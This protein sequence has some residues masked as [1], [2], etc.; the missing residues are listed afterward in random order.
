MPTVEHMQDDLD[1]VAERQELAANPEGLHTNGADHGH[2]P[3]Q[4]GERP[5]ES[6][7]STLGGA[8]DLP[9]TQSS[10]IYAEQRLEDTLQSLDNTV[11]PLSE[12]PVPETSPGAPTTVPVSITGDIA[13]VRQTDLDGLGDFVN[14][15]QMTNTWHLAFSKLFTP[16]LN[17]GVSSY[18]VQPNSNCANRDRAIKNYPDWHKWNMWRSDGRPAKHPTIVCS[19]HRALQAS[20]IW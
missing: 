16:I 20:T 8:M 6:F 10:I 13:T 17:D 19:C 3:M 11:A 14:T 5:D 15:R 4:S 12:A 2:A 7:E 9:S 1:P 18:F